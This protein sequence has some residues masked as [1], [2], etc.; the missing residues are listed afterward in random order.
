MKFAWNCWKVD[1]HT[2]HSYTAVT[3]FFFLALAFQ[4]IFTKCLYVQL[5]QQ[6]FAP[7]RSNGYML[8]LLSH[9]QHKAHELG[10]KLVIIVY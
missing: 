7:G 3:V 9:P 1:A 5:V 10:M 8:L 6:K 2:E 4:V